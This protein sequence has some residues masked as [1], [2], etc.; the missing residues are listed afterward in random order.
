LYRGAPRRFSVNKH[1]KT[2]PGRLE[3]QDIDL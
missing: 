1:A 2:H 3:T